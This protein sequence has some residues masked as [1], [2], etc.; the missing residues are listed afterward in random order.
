MHVNFAVVWMSVIVKVHWVSPVGL[1]IFS[2]VRK[3][4]QGRGSMSI[5][6]IQ[7]TQKTRG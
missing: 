6:A 1:V 7:P 3:A 4:K 2:L 5:K